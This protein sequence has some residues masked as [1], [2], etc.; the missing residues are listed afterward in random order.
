MTGEDHGWLEAKLLLTLG[1]H[2]VANQLGRFYPGN[3]DFVLDGEPGNIRLQYQP[4]VGFLK[5]EHVISTPGYIY[6]APDLAIEIISPSQTFT[7]IRN[8]VKNYL[9]Y[10]SQQVWIVMPDAKEIEDTS[11]D[12]PKTYTVGEAIPGGD[13]LPGLMLDVQTIFEA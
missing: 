10:G 7:E 6:R 11:T 5:T 4:D 1:N 8:K 13:L 3:T 9:K 12:A 2:I